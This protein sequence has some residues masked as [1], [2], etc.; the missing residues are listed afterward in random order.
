MK[1]ANMYIDAVKYKMYHGFNIRYN[2]GN[3]VSL[4]KHWHIL[5]IIVGLKNLV[6]F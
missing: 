6:I 4:K 5:D 2:A 1:T 3:K